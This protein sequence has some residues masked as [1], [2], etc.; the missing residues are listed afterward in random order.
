MVEE[1]RVP[2]H[3]RIRQRFP[4]PVERDPQL[5]VRR[6]LEQLF[7][8]GSIREGAEIAVTVGSRGIEGIARITR[9]VVDFLRDRR[10]RP[11]ILP[12]MGSHGG[13]AAEAQAHLIAHYGVTEET[14][15][16]PVRPAME[17][18]SLGRTR[19]GVEVRVAETA[20]AADG[21][22][23]VNRVKPHTDYKGELESGLAKIS[24]IGLGKYDGAREIHSH[25]FD[26]GLGG[27]IREVS[28]TIV[29]TG[30]V[31]GGLAILE[32]A[33]HE[34]ARIA[35]VPAD[36]LF[37]REAE[38]L[39][40]ARTLMP[41]LPLDELEVLWCQYLGKNISGAG[42]DT[43]IIGRSVYGYT[44]GVPWCEGMP[45]ILRIIVSDITDESDGNAVGMGLADYATDRFIGKVDRRVTEINAMTA[46]SPNGAKTP[47]ILANDLECL[48]AAI[49][50]AR[51]RP[52][53]PRVV[54]IRDTLSLESVWVSEACLAELRD[55]EDID[56]LG[57]PEE[58]KF[59]TKGALGELFE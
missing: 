6:E 38:L 21:I 4:R 3:V 20:Y 54:L 47:I 28:E 11:F 53:G 13:A 25:I 33:Y 55:R 40:E 37:E 34:T 18:R 49:R 36:R 41:R 43:N 10:A 31:I 5:A 39:R 14:M 12:A 2:R 17:T 52:G 50:T 26:V 8:P 15:G 44:P 51:R 46:C 59:D 42:M 45:G 57:E 58:L 7:P 35:G 27:A 23:L 24:A 56:I 19:S 30:K 1:L 9:A 32:N 48:L 16:C 29:G 22:L